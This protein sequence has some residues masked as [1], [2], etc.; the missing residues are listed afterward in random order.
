MRKTILALAAALLLAA[1]LPVAAQQASPAD[2][3]T[4]TKLGKYVTAVEAADMLKADAGAALV[5]VRTI[6]A[7]YYV[8][9]AP[10]AY[11]IPLRFWTGKWDPEK[12]DF[13]FALNPRFVQGVAERFPD[14]TATLLVFS[15]A[16]IFGARAV[17]LLADAGYVNVYNVT[18]GFQ[19][20]QKAKLP[21]T[22][23]LDPNLVY[24]IKKQ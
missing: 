4:A 10:E 21:T 19:G 24:V 11:N 18:D 1:A 16:G 22:R 12:N 14:K 6:P 13:A 20:W 17:S 5:D 9:H 7:Y 2:G 15:R 3:K 23:K 8:G